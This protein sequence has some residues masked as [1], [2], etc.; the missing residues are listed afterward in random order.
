V[1]AEEIRELQERINKLKREKESNDNIRMLK[2]REAKYGLSAKLSHVA[3]KHPFLTLPAVQAKRAVTNFTFPHFSEETKRK[4]R[5][6]AS[7]L[8]AHMLRVAS[9]R[10]FAARLREGQTALNRQTGDLITKTKETGK[11]Y[12]ATKKLV[13][14]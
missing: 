1:D 12:I 2:L 7:K 13:K 5:D 4:F 10:A 8:H 9:N 14:V 3:A 6:V 11:G